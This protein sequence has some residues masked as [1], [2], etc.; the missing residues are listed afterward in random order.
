M[1]MSHSA[2]YGLAGLLLITLGSCAPATQLTSSW[3]DPTAGS[4]KY[5]KV[6][7]V[8][9]SPQAGLRRKYEEAFTEELKA[10][11]VDAVASYTFGGEG[12]LE[13]EA[14]IA[15]LK[16]VGA[17]GVIVTRLIDQE[18]VQT[19]Y[20]PSYSVPSTYYGGWYGYYSMGYGYMTSPGY[21][22]EDKVFRIETN[23]YDVGSDK[24]TWSGLTKTTLTSGDAPENEI[25]PLIQTLLIDME[26]HKL[27]A[28]PKK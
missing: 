20:P 26:K 6:V 28:P 7:V 16:E 2:W 23:L 15:K 9:A 21:M 8:G 18:S 24:L 5:Q 27:V 12:Q 1:K 11:G 10:R 14:A 3:A 22:V 17:D 13:K 4:H 25:R 19:Y